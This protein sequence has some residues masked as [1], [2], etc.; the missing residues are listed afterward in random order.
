MRTFL[1]GTVL[2]VAIL[3]GG[4]SA[5]SS[6]PVPLQAD[7][8]TPRT[9][10]SA[11]VAQVEIATD[12]GTFR[13]VPRRCDVGTDPDRGVVE[14]SIEGPG[15]APDGQPIYVTA[16]DEDGDPHN[17][18]EIRINVG[19]DQR[20]RTPDLV[21]IVNDESANSLRVPAA[22]AK[23]EGQ[24]VTVEGAVFIGNGDDRLSATAPIRFD[25]SR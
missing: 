11:E 12:S 9:H 4:C 17:S 22:R 24:S 2:A 6:Q 25:C 10:A 14:Y 8:A 1:G 13:F 3:T 19:T 20:L 16:V 21:W 7:P 5:D 23:V 18:P 15:Q